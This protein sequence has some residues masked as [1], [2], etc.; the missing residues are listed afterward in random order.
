MQTPAIT[1]LILLLTNVLFAQDPKEVITISEIIREAISY[2]SQEPLVIENKIIKKDYPKNSLK[3]ILSDVSI[4]LDSNGYIIVDKEIRIENSVIDQ[5][6][7]DSI[8]FTSK[9]L[10]RNIKLDGWLNFNFCAIDELHINTL[11]AEESSIIGGSVNIRHSNISHFQSNG[12]H[13]ST[14]MVE[15]SEIGNLYILGGDIEGIM[16]E[17][18]KITNLGIKGAHNME[19]LILSNLIFKSSVDFTE[20]KEVGFE[21]DDIYVTTT[22]ENGFSLSQSKIGRILIENCD[23]GSTMLADVRAESF[24]LENNTFLKNSIFK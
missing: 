1:F 18:V 14:M 3:S 4:Q 11:V 13:T 24:T 15:Y 2:N 22:F 19:W 7:F 16:I 21:G 17:E 6:I 5:V 8:H 23:F 9:I 12:F 20:L 10:F